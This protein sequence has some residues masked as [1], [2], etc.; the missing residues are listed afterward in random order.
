MAKVKGPGGIEPA[1][2][3]QSSLITGVPG[4]SATDLLVDASEFPAPPDRYS[5]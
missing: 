5:S 2:P 1:D 3:P 4:P